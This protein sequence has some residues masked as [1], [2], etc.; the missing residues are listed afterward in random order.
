MQDL[1]ERVVTLLQDNPQAD[2]HYMSVGDE[3]AVESFDVE[4]EALGQYFISGLQF[5]YREFS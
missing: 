3:I 2:C 5:L 4:Q 1:V